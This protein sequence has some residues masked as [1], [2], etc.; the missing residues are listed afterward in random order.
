MG[1]YGWIIGKAGYWRIN[2][3]DVCEQDIDV[4]SVGRNIKRHFTGNCF[5][6]L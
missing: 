2:I 6:A 1:E 4:R 5:L 3:M